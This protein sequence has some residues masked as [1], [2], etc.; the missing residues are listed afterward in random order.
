MNCRACTMA[1]LKEELETLQA[2]KNAAILA[3]EEWR[4]R[5][6][7]EA[8]SALFSDRITI[9]KRYEDYRSTVKGHVDCPFNVITFL[10][11]AGYLRDPET[12]PGH[13]EARKRY[14][15]KVKGSTD[16]KA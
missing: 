1:A 15:E 16:G 7:A 6:R 4:E 11:I 10:E 13:I 14:L 12:V 5:S 9:E 3:L 8:S 2:E